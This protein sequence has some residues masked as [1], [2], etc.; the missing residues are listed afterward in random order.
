MNTLTWVLLPGVKV[1]MRDIVIGYA[2]YLA[3]AMF[4]W[5]AAMASSV[6]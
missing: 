4:F 1:V 2:R 6:G 5:T 3:P